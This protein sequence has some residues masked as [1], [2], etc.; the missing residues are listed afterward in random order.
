MDFETSLQNAREYIVRALN[1][2]T[3]PYRAEEDYGYFS[4][5]RGATPVAR[6]RFDIELGPTVVRSAGPE[7]VA[8]ILMSR[9]RTDLM[10]ML[11]NGDIESP[12]PLYKV[13][14]GS[15]KRGKTLKNA[16]AF[17]VNLAYKES[18]SNNSYE[19]TVYMLVAAEWA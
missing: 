1:G 14:D 7:G 11:E 10:D 18:P 19:Y 6:L 5:R 13:I 2:S 9:V 4:E 16:D 15:K 3:E 17:A 8:D 12:Q